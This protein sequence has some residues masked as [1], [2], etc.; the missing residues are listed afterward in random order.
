INGFHSLAPKRWDDTFVA[1][2]RGGY[3]CVAP[4]SFGLCITPPIIAHLPAN[5]RPDFV[6]DM[7]RK[8]TISIWILRR[9]YTWNRKAGSTSVFDIRTLQIENSLTIAARSFDEFVKQPLPLFNHSTVP[10]QFA[11]FTFQCS[12]LTSE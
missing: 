6:P 9:R 8:D 7:A 3:N 10:E 12:F 1:S 2:A 5:C 11:I 4:S